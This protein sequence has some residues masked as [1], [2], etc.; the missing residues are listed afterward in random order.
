MIMKNNHISKILNELINI[1]NNF[2][3]ELN[4]SDF[5]NKVLSLVP[6]HENLIKLGTSLIPKE[7]AS[8]ARDRIILYFQKY[9]LTVINSKEIMIIAGISEW[10]RRVR[11]LRVQFG[12]SIISGITAKE[13]NSENDFNNIDLMVGSMHPDDYILI[14]ENQDRDAAHRW[15]LGNNI[16]KKDGSV[17]DKILEYMRLNIG[18]ILS[19]EELRYVSNDK[20]E[21]ARRVRELRTEFG[22][23]VVSKNSG[24][25]D[26]PIGTYIL[27]EDRQSP[28][29]DRKIPDGTRS[30]VLMRDKYKCQQCGWTQKLW[31]KSD[32]RHLELHHK[33]S[34]AD[35]GENTKYN[36]ITLCTVCH[37][38]L[39]SRD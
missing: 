21:W 13:M 17:R 16:R 2:E 27:E 7:Y 20:T 26:L 3:K 18:K 36:L 15:N 37:D 22:W 25:P 4:K 11:E 10:A 38:E 1:L 34:H 5:R 28:P 35:K 24:R 33:K 12:W 32:P 6:A 14:N 30:E 19:G 23:P 29:H 9:P 31:N 8:S 39:H